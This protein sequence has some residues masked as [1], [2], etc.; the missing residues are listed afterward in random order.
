[1]DPRQHFLPFDD[2]VAVE[3]SV[4]AT[5]ATNAAQWT[6]HQIGG[7]NTRRDLLRRGFNVYNYSNLIAQAARDR[8]GNIQTAEYLMP[9][10]S[11]TISER[12]D[13]A[14]ACGA[15]FGVVTGRMNSISGLDWKVTKQRKIEDRIVSKLKIA[16]DIY[17][18]VMENPQQMT[19]RSMGSLIE[20]KRFVRQY[21]R[22]INDDFSNFDRSLL[23]WSRTL[24]EKH[25]DEC[26][27]IEDWLKKPNQGDT[28]EDFTKKLIFDTHV[29]GVA[30]PYKK[31]LGKQI[32]S[33]HVLPGGSCFPIRG[34]HI[35]DAIGVLQIIDGAEAQLFYEDE[36]GVL[37]YSPYSGDPYG[38]VPLEALTN[39]V[40]EI[41]LFDE[42]AAMMA[43]GTKPPDKLIAFGENTPWGNLQHTY[44][45]PLDKGEQKRI[46]TM[47][48]EAR[49]EAIRVISGHG[50]PVVVDISRAD[51]FKDQS[52]RQRMV[53]E[54]VALVFGASNAEMNLTGNESTS[55]RSSSETQERKDYSKGIYPHIQMLENFW[56]MQI[57]PFRFGHGYEFSYEP[58]ASEGEMVEMWTKKLQS[59]LFSVNEIRREDIGRD[60]FDGEE[61]EKPQVGG[62][63]QAEG[64]DAGMM[65]PPGAV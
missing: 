28:F 41:L 43:D 33:L 19:L 53:R 23:R 16:R 48:N 56:N 1:M 65:A 24:K 20:V 54:E 52:E 11:L 10:F 49:K 57:F 26:T 5:A 39:K 17:Q 12:I 44:E 21:L 29:H 2:P 60:G 63:Q 4:M 35:G 3:K 50:T 7:V 47:V 46:E 22:D 36:V 42:R 45:I 51:T 38:T 62:G 55:G 37:Q 27:R 9:Y 8:Y 32:E 59:G 15:I 18:E 61:F 31:R 30:V 14:R 25:E 13:M 58:T 6:S 64:M 34:R 40:A